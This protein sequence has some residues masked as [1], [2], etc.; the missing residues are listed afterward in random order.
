MCLTVLFCS[1]YNSFIY[2][3][4]NLHQHREPEESADEVYT[5]QA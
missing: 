2:R 5:C 1:L 4:I 3:V